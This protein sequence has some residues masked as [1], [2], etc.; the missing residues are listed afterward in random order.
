MGCGNSSLYS[1]SSPRRNFE[2]LKL[3]NGYAKR[4]SG[5]SKPI[6]HK[7]GHKL[8]SSSSSVN[9]NGGVVARGGEVEEKKDEDG[10]ISKRF[11]EKKIGRDEFVDG[12]PK[13]L[14]DNIP[15]EGLDGLH[16]KSA[17]S[18]EKLAKVGR[19]TYSNVYK[20][21][22][23]ESGKI[24]ALKK[25]RFD[26][27][28]SESIK[29][30]AREITILRKLDHPNVI[31]LEGLATSR[32]QYSLYLVFD[33]MHSDLTRIITRPGET[34][35]EPQIKC[36]M[37][38]LLA[39]LQHCHEKGVM[40]RDIKPSNLF[41][42]KR[43]VLK[44]GD[45]GLSIS[46]VHKP[47]G[48]FTNRVVTLWYRAPELLLGSTD[49]GFGI[50]LWSAGCIL[51]EMFFGRPIMRGRT[52]V[53]QLHMIFKLFGSPSEDYWKNLNL[54]TSYRPPQYYKPN[55]E[56]VFSDFP[57]SSLALL[58][59]LLDLHPARRGSAA[60]ALQSEFFK[61][62]PLPCA[63]SALPV[64]SKD[65]DEQS[66]SRKRRRPKMTKKDPKF[67][68]SRVSNGQSRTAEKLKGD[69][70]FSKEEKSMEPNMLSQEMGNGASSTSSGSKL[71]MNDGNTKAPLS[72]VFVSGP[73]TE[74][75]PNALKNIKKYAL[76][77]ATII[78]MI[79]PK[80]GNEFA[81]VRRSFSAL[82][83]RLDPDKLPNFYGMDEQLDYQI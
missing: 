77:Q 29:F 23:K 21:R 35:T 10:N 19:G 14:V 16:P 46:N 4:N 57:S 32:M 36:Y 15:L 69:S 41:V 3:E 12:W 82:D 52:E 59:T 8:L 48:P 9:A 47:K 83:F 39:G 26:T 80:E 45:F 38:Q 58:A 27:S 67:Q 74:G 1:E 65:E 25:V 73:R 50:D 7:N 53:E 70:E 54:M 40:H 34:L 2:R 75:H 31:K 24:V 60:S 61:T 49:Y 72:P 30:M 66:R 42:D 81:Q 22:D 13:W 55:Y 62:P 17:D 20:A 76:L 6:S 79:N 5:G 11:V 63:P 18:Y 37:Q 44:I 78:D 64:I 68:T 43:G 51:A 28:D 71:F 33:F 56:E